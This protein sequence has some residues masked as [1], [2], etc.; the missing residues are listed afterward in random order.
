[1]KR[2]INKYLKDNKKQTEKILRKF[3][4]IKSIVDAINEEE[5]LKLKLEEMCHKEISLINWSVIRQN[6][7]TFKSYTYAK[8]LTLR[9]IINQYLENRKLYP[10]TNDLQ[11]VADEY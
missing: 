4:G 5:L 10:Y 9:T 7:D 8:Y 6:Y 1:M 2:Q 11:E 3:F